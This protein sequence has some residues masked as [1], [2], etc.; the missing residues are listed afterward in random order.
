[1]NE[2]ERASNCQRGRCINTMGSYRCEC[3]KGYMPVSG[4]RCQ[5]VEIVRNDKK[6]CYLNLDDTVFCDSVLA[7]NVTKQEC[8]CSIG[9]GWGD[10]CEIYPCPVYRSAEYLSLCPVGRGFYHEEGKM[11]YGLS[12]R[13]DIDECVLFSNEIC[14][15][16][17]CMNTQPG[18]E[19][20]CQQGF[21][22][23]SNLLECIGKI[24]HKYTHFT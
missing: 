2:C 15:E 3:Q 9:V 6:E 13:R 10:H 5:E 12:L 22:Y 4:R 23:D 1:I 14:K 17:R 21:Y 19:C 24:T 18:F 16:G 7:T 20:Y 11:E 8:C